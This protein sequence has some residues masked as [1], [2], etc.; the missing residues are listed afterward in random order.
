MTF[1]NWKR[2]IF[3]S[4]FTPRSSSSEIS[5]GKSSGME[6][7]GSI[8]KRTNLHSTSSFKRP[9]DLNSH[10]S[11]LNPVSSQYNLY[12]NAHKKW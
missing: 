8:H 7:A 1:L 6:P 3:K 5:I 2:F 4:S 12:R 10:R 11:P 9:T